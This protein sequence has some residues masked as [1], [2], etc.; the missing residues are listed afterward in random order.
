MKNS[1]KL[2]SGAV[3]TALMTVSTGAFASCG[4]SFCSLETSLDSQGVLTEPGQFGL[5]LR[6]EFVKQ[7]ALRAGNKSISQSETADEEAT[8]LTTY[9]RNLIATLTYAVTP[10]WGLAASLPFVSRSH[11]HIEDPAGAAEHESWSFSKLSDARIFG[12]YHFDR[13]HDAPDSFGMQFGVKLPTGDYKGDNAEGVVAERSLQPG[14]GTTDVIIGGHY[15]YKPAFKQIT[16]FV[17]AQYQRALAKR[18]DYRAGDQLSLTGGLAYAYADNAALMFQLNG[19]SK[20]RDSG[21]QAEPEVSGGRYIFASPG[22]RYAVGKAMQ[23]YGFAQVPI[24]RNVNGIQLT[25]D[26]SLVAGVTLKI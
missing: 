16:Y 15:A 5:D 22:M 4:S 25:A 18:D 23:V 21:D 24:Y 11:S 10:Q 19:M 1:R 3:V 7:D 2:R 9:N 17:N 8:E 14:T 12:R 20:S 6:F 26:W 13:P